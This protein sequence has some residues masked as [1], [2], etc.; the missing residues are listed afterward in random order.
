MDQ[1]SYYLICF[2]ASMILTGVYLFVWKKNFDPHITLVFVLIP[3]ITFSHLQL[4][5]AT[6]LESALNAY[7][8]TVI[9]GCFLQMIFMFTAFS[10]C[11][12]HL[13]RWLKLFFMLVSTLVFLSALTIGKKDWYYKNA[14]LEQNGSSY[15]L[16]KEYGVMHSVFYILVCVYFIMSL[17][18]IIYA[19]LRKNQISRKILVLLF[20]PELVCMLSF[21][22]G[23]RAF[24][25]IELLPAA[26]I[27][28]QMM[29]LAIVYRISL[30]DVTETAV[31]T[32][33]ESGSA[34]F[35]TFDLDRCY[36]GSNETAKEI[37]PELNDLTVDL[38]LR[39]NQ[40]LWELFSPRLDA[41]ESHPENSAENQFHYEKD[42]KI[43]SCSIEWL[44]GGKH[45]RG[46]QIFIED[47]TTDQAYIKL[48]DG[49]N[50]DLKNEVEA[51]TAN[52]VEMHNNLVLSMATMIESRDNSTGGHIRRTSEGVR[53]LINAMKS[54]P[55][56]PEGYPM[57]EE[58]C[59][60]LIKAAPMHDLGKIAVDDDILR[61]P[62][63]FTPEEFE[64]MK[65]H[66][67]EG[68]R[69]VH[70]ILKATDDR[71]FH[72]IAENVA[73]YH[74]ERWDGSGY[75]DKLKG[76][77]IPPEARIMAIA[78]VYDALVSKRVYKD[79]MSFEKANNIIMESMGSQF[80]PALE[81][82]YLAA[83]PE[84]EAYY[85]ESESSG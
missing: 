39:N 27:F 24:S 6:T 52:L 11:R 51:K 67:A 5:Q 54:L 69:I 55:E 57:N 47:D 19:F 72:V 25:Q 37:F 33:A 46:Y 75:P 7:K 58:F 68:A 45:K 13:N 34:G 65:T 16:V 10:L 78:D 26:Y 1:T 36:L 84:L 50:S 15:V 41:F 80:D 28:V 77:K 66:A 74:H 49:Y 17:G 14:Y 31:E 43:Y 85:E 4:A 53:L 62:G 60:N 18:A 70:E 79:S 12:I 30:Y 3:L 29:Y 42:D 20:L 81:P 44:S 35:V 9:G 83:K 8:Y 56:P 63:R 59:R 38:S 73:H 48:L 23:R 22:G 61:K 64:I 71:S 40:K 2:L 32:M 21:F 82:V 76:E